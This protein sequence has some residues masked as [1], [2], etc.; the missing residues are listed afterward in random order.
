MNFRDFWC[1]IAI[2]VLMSELMRAERIVA[3]IVAP[4]FAAF[5]ERI[6]AVSVLIRAQLADRVA[7][8]ELFARRNF[9]AE[10]NTARLRAV[11][12]IMRAESITVEL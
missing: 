11:S 1:Q 10:S 5:W 4:D 3:R 2:A 7:T 12:A 8:D 9:R 6:A